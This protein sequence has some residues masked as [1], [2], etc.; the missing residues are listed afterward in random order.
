MTVHGAWIAEVIIRLDRTLL[1]KTRDV[2]AVAPHY[3]LEP[4]EM[5]GFLVGMH[6]APAVQILEDYIAYAADKAI[7]AAIA[8]A[9]DLGL[10]EIAGVLADPKARCSLVVR[11][12]NA[13]AAQSVDLDN[14]GKTIMDGLQKS[15]IMVADQQVDTLRIDSAYSHK[16]AAAERIPTYVSVIKTK[17]GHLSFVESVGEHVGKAFVYPADNALGYFRRYQNTLYPNAAVL[18]R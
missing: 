17:G 11:L 13:E 5:D 8:E 1:S 6:N 12:G 10:T 3:S 7:A 16:I 14:V 4:V 2:P 18:N 9:Q 15:S